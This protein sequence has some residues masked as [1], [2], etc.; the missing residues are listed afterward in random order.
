RSDPAASFEVVKKEWPKSDLPFTHEG[1]PIELRAKGKRIPE[2]KS[3]YLGLVG[4][5]Q[6][7]PARSN[8]PVEPITL[9]PMGAA[10]LRIAAFPVIGDGPDAHQWVVPPEARPTKVSASHCFAN[11]TVRA[12]EDGLVPKN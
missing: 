9:I 8:E 10:R 2:W 1:T 11:D 12:V 6:D 4:L 7:S 3:D 5:L